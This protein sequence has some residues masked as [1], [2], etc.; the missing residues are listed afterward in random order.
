MNKFV[1]LAMAMA[2]LVAQPQDAS[3]TTYQVSGSQSRI[4]L[5]V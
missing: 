1:S 5:R 2:D 4:G 3:Q